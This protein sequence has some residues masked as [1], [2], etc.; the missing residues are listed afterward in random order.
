M[1]QRSTKT[2]VLSWLSRVA[3]FVAAAYG[4]GYLAGYFTSIPPAISGLVIGVTFF[5]YMGWCHNRRTTQP[6][7]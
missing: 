3:F 2:S 6:G 1:H 4:V 5:L 7:L